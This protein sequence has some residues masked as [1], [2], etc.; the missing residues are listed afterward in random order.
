MASDQSGT[1]EVINAR[2][3]ESA[4]AVAIQ[5]LITDET[6]AVF[7]PVNLMNLMYVPN[8][9]L[10]VYNVFSQNLINFPVDSIS[11]VFAKR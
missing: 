8:L 7:G 5:K 11:N 3:T 4:D 9:E 2:R 10:S 1:T 6:N